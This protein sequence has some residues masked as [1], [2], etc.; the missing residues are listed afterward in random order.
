MNNLIELF[1]AEYRDTITRY[2]NNLSDIFDKYDVAI[3]M[4]RKA[5]CF[6]KALVLEKYLQKPTHCKVVSS[7]VLD[8]NV[9][10]DFKGKKIIVIDDLWYAASLWQKPRKFCPITT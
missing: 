3:F 1:P 4:A 8:Y 5:I 9:F 2:K 10:D 7:R 6:Y